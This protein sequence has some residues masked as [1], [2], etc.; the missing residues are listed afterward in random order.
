MTM[1]RPVF[2]R[3]VG[4]VARPGVLCCVVV[5]AAA[6][7]TATPDDGG[8]GVLRP[9]GGTSSAVTSSGS[10]SGLIPPDDGGTAGGATDSLEPAPDP[11]GPPAAATLPWL[12]GPVIDDGILLGEPGNQ[13]W[14]GREAGESAVITEGWYRY[15]GPDGSAVG[16][17]TAGPCVGVGWDGTIVVTLGPQQPRQVFAADGQ[18]LGLFTAGGEAIGADTGT[19]TSAPVTSAG[20]PETG[21]PETGQPETGQPPT[22]PASTSQ[23]ASETSPPP[24][25]LT[26]AEAIAASGVDVAGLLN[27]ATLLPPFAGG[28]TGDP[29]II[30]AG[31]L[32]YSTQVTGQYVARTG[33]PTRQIQLE[34][35]PMAHR[36][37]VS[38]VT[39]A[40]I[41][42]GEDV[43]V[44]DSSGNVT[45]GTH[46]QPRVTAFEQ[47]TLVEGVTIG[48]WPVD[49]RGVAAVV[50]WWPDGSAVTI[51][52]HPALGMTLIAQ[53]YP[54]AAATGL[55]GAAA[56]A[57][58]PGPDLRQRSGQPGSTTEQAISSWSVRGGERLLP[59][60]ALPPG[61][62]SPALVDPAAKK[63][64]RQWCSV[65]GMSREQDIAACV[66]DVA[67]TGDTAFVPSHLALAMAARPRSIPGPFAGR[68]PALTTGAA[69]SAEELP[70]D[71]R[72]TATLPPA[73]AQSYRFSL[74]RPGTVTLV[75]GAGCAAGANPPG[76]DQPAARLFDRAGHAVSDRAAL[77]GH[78]DSPALPAGEYVLTIAN[79][80]GQPPLP[81][82]LDVQLP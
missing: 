31:G 63:V 53:L 34:L 57:G 82:R 10:A 1:M 64:A 81:V 78:A 18:P 59:E 26:L 45:I 38:V 48:R 43:I 51:R 73:T 52:A 76:I 77:C 4:R 67:I 2:Q 16:C 15:F 32:R 39:A 55:F 49:D 44:V 72:I 19:T 40:A 6:A 61:P 20:Q 36:T 70:G 42:T 13:R 22:E 79:G 29:H 23:S 33:D 11:T 24:G 75:N 47:L 35:S 17:V 28:V 30:T 62:T 46:P 41:G 5:I 27:S 54:A 12:A 3:P 65:R 69:A 68:W 66:F 25:D 8:T 58:L 21:Q 14:H 74:D 71:G 80:A 37:D 60:P 7:C 9:S 56:Q 50:V